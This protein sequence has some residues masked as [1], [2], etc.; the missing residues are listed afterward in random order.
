MKR[1]GAALP[2]AVALCTFL[3]I[4]TFTVTTLILEISTINTI[5]NME[6]KRNILFSESHNT[7]VSNNGDISSITDETYTWAT[8]NGENN[9]KA[10]VAYMKNGNTIKFYSIYDF[11]NSKTLAYQTSVIYTTTNSEGVTMLGGIVPIGE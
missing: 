7:F 2:T 6:T 4:I 8:Y 10:L 9:I 11:D 5:N 1:K 3:L